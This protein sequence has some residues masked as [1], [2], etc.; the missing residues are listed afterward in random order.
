MQKEVNI[1]VSPE[2][3]ADASLL[4]IAVS[5]NIRIPSGEIRYIEI[6]KRSIDARQRKIKVN[7]RVRVYVQE[8]FEEQEIEL[9]DYPFVGNAPEVL[10]I[11]A[12]P[13]GLFAALRL[14]ELGV[15]PIV[16]ERGK[17]VRARR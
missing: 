13:A 16:L 5:K 14:I 2:Q 12:G 1:Q 10:V 11:G 3:A 9:P 17:D 8:D 4:K 7:L 6:L 15:R